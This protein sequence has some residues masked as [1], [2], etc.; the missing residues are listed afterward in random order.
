MCV[1]HQE[2]RRRAPLGGEG[3]RFPLTARRRAG[4]VSADGDDVAG[5]PLASASLT[6]LDLARDSRPSP[7]A[8]LPSGVD[9]REERRSID[10]RG[11]L[12]PLR[13]PG[14]SK[15]ALWS[16]EK[17][18]RGLIHECLGALTV[19]GL[20]SWGAAMSRGESVRDKGD[21]GTADAGPCGSE[22]R[23][24]SGDDAELAAGAVW[25]ALSLLKG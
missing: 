21:A 24:M 20:S 16:A 2:E 3:L 17:V 1:A 14:R 23:S 18:R 25:G 9:G 8:L 6:F 19:V 22:D 15:E 11:E 5:M 10:M 7:V 4:V 13:T 12:V